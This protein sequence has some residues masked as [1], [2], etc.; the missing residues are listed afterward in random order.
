M[1]SRD[2]AAPSASEWST[3]RAS[4]PSRTA[5][6]ATCSWSPP[7]TCSLQRST[8][9]PSSIAISV[10]ALVNEAQPE[11]EAYDSTIRHSLV[12]PATTSVR[13]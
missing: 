12:R 1:S 13:A 4:R 5:S 9:A 8:R 2:S 6:V 10:T 11:S 7:S 3:K